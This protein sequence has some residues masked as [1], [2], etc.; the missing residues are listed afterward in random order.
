MNERIGAQ[1]REVRENFGFSLEELAEFSDIP[2]ERVGAI[3]AGHAPSTWEI[4]ALAGAL[5]IDPGALWRGEV[6]KSPMRST[7]RFRS[8]GG[9]TFILP[10]DARLLAKAAEIGRIVGYLYKQL[11]DHNS[12]VV[13]ARNVLPIEVYPE[14]WDQG[15]TLGAKARS[16]LLPE[17]KPIVSLER[18]LERLGVV[19][20]RL[21]LD[22]SIQAVS[23]YEPGSA[24]VIVLNTGAIRV[25][26]A[27][28]RRALLAHEL[29]HLLH[30]GGEHDFLTLVSRYG[31]R[32]PVEQRANGFAPNFLVPGGLLLHNA[33]PDTLH[34][35]IFS[36][37][38]E[39]GLSFEGAAWHA[40][41]AGRITVQECDDLLAQAKEAPTIVPEHG[42]EP[43]IAHREP[44]SI[45]L[46]CQPS[47]LAT[48]L[49]TEVTLRALEADIVTAG[50]A[51]EILTTQ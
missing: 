29:C 39:W 50:R 13:N 48:G 8:A 51:V 47:A 32:E 38:R 18:E 15:Y 46:E 11:G 7:A 20:L 5:A 9:I 14:P 21:A 4:S 45:G 43:P 16:S 1:V 23:L 6:G 2:A 41:N 28:S 12:P 42:F 44:A 10:R 27:L 3:E 19:V 35:F 37:A 49:V 25:Q 17:R 22:K 40:K 26:A 30:D 36:L 31:A 24:P 34:D 33:N